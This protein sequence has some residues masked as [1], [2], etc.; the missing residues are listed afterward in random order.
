[1]TRATGQ[2]VRAAWWRAPARFLLKLALALAV[3]CVPY[4]VYLDAVVTRDFESHRWTVPARVHA[5]PLV[6][7]AGQPLTAGMLL[8]ELRELG[9]RETA[10]PVRPGEYAV[11]VAGR[12]VSLVT[13]GFPFPDGAT[14][15]QSV[16]AVFGEAQVESL[17]AP[18]TRVRLEPVVIGTLRAQHAEDRVLMRLDQRPPWLVEALLATEDRDFP[19]HIGVSPRGLLRAL[20]V[21]LSAGEVQQGGSTLTQQLVKNFYLDSERTLARKLNEAVM[22]LLL[23]AHYDKAVILETYCNEIYLGQAGRRAVHGFALASE[24]YFGRPVSELQLHEVAL[25]VGLVKGPSQYNPWKH[26]E[27][28]RER[29]DVVIAALRATGAIG[30]PEAEAARAQPLGVL[31]SPRLRLN[32]YPAFMAMVRRELQANLDRATLAADGL[33]VF[34]TLDPAVQ[35]AAESAVT[36]TLPRIEQERG[37][38]GLEAALVVAAPRSGEVLAAVGGRD[39]DFAG[40]DRV[41]DARRTIGSLMKPVVLLAALRQPEKYSLATQVSDAPV[42]VP[43]KGGAAWRPANYDHVS[44]GEPPDHAVMLIDVIAHSWNL[45][46]ARLGL[47]LGVPAVIDEARRLGVDAELPPYPAVLL[48]SATLSPAEVLA[49]YQPMAAGGERVPPHA[50]RAVLAAD[51]R[52]LFAASPPRRQVMAPATVWLLTYALQETF[53][54]G[55]ARSANEVLSP[56]V[57][58]AGKTGTTDNGRDSWFAGYTGSQV[59]V[60]WVGHDDYRPTS[61]SGASGALRIWA[62]LARRLPQRPNPAQSPESVEWAWLAPGGERRSAEGCEGARYLPVVAGTVPRESTLCATASGALQGVGGFF[63]RLLD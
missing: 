35:R 63:R 10:N 25:L 27:R 58:A 9:Y 13:R 20:Y 33:T 19:T 37:L 45:A 15:S 28:A 3:V 57:A 23:E 36:E 38:K 34:T 55:T 50:L 60:A 21:N 30:E 42:V 14:P 12:Q 56:A 31:P 54:T 44:H 61:L 8:A 49:M 11:D 4:V 29:R 17:R 59:A 47:D 2:P 7:Q 41:N 53:R 39:V 48:G 24:F 18:G 40:F 22:S 51:G 62:D 26:P 46:T 1:M 16:V 43:M 52:V 6:L 32:R 5:R